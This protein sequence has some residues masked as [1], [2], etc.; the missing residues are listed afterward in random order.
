[1]CSL[2]VAFASATVRNRSCDPRIAVPMV[3]SAEVVI[4][5]GFKRLVASFC[6]AG[7]MLLRR[8]QKM[9]CS[10][11]GRRSTLDVSI[12][13]FRGRRITLDVSC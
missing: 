8:F 7:A 10:F 3:S 13:I 11:R 2:D 5:G 9:R 6:V 4:F 12:V 1:M